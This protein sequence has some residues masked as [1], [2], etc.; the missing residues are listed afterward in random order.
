V[1]WA[2]QINTCRKVPL[3]VNLFRWRHCALPSM[4]ILSSYKTLDKTRSVLQLVNCTVCT[5]WPDGLLGHAHQLTGVL[6]GLSR[7][8][9]GDGVPHV[10]VR[11]HVDQ[12]GPHVRLKNVACIYRFY[13]RYRVR[14]SRLVWAP[15][16]QPMGARTP[17]E[18]VQPDD[19][20]LSPPGVHRI[21]LVWAW[22]LIYTILN[23]LNKYLLNL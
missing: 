23:L 1:V 3:Q 5:Q 14:P 21:C 10:R 6:G 12:D 18:T 7:R 4:S 2:R 13:I 9:E 16:T 22:Y 11:I 15:G 20:S 17:S 8:G 19:I